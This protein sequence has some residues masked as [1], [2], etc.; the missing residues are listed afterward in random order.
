MSKIRNSAKGQPCMVRIDPHLC[1]SNE[2]TVLAHNNGGGMGKKGPDF[3]GAFACSR[4]HD[5]IDG[6]EQTKYRKEEIRAMFIDGILH[7]QNWLFYNDFIKTP[8]SK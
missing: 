6:R 2:T 5:V 4:C 8:G 1:T 7:T 3:Q